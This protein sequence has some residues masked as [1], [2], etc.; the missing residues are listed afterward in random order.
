MGRTGR[1]GI[2]KSDPIDARRIAASVLP[3]GACASG[4]HVQQVWSE[5]QSAQRSP[6]MRC[7]RGG[8]AAVPRPPLFRIFPLGFQKAGIG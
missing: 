7:G 1:R 3:L 8:A 6:S 2:G 4:G 5:P